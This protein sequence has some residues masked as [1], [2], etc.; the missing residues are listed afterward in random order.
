MSKKNN[1]INNTNI[2]KSIFEVQ[3]TERK[4]IAR[5]LHDTTLH[6]L[7]Y[8]YHKLELLSLYIENDSEK[9]KTEL[10]NIKKSLK[11]TMNDIRNIIFDL[12][13][14]ILDD[15][16]LKEAFGVFFNWLRKNTKFQYILDIDTIDVDKDIF[17]NIYRIVV[18]CIM[19]AVKYSGGTQIRFLCKK[20]KNEIVICVED[21]GKGFEKNNISNTRISHGM[22]IVR[23]RVKILNG[24]ITYTTDIGSGLKI[25]I[26]IP[27][28]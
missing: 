17:L 27:L 10:M 21:N 22:S 26:V 14:A 5:D 25:D 20:F 11:H 15:L 13:P 3:E 1:D 19:N 7:T 24:S 12:R 9:A 6:D 2:S 8:I 23:E 4:R 18:E 16:G 28:N